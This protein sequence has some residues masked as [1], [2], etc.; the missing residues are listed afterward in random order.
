MAASSFLF[1]DTNSP[2]ANVFYRAVTLSTPVSVQFG[3]PQINGLGQFQASLSG[4]VGTPLVIETSPDL[5]TWTP[6]ATNA[7]AT[8]SILFTDTNSPSAN[9]FY[10]ATT[11]P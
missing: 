2:G 6:I 5:T 1:T 7:M 10:R 4:Q 3:P 8:S 9:L 11:C